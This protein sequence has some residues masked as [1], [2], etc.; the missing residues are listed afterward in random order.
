MIFKHVKIP[1]YFYCNKLSVWSILLQNGT[2]AFRGYL[3]INFIGH[4]IL[5]LRI[6]RNLKE[7]EGILRN[8][9]EI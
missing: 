1:F 2:S 3:Y 7:S 4:V 5:D 9:K 6:L 8:V